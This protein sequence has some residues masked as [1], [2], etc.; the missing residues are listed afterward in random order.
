E[1]YDLAADPNQRNN[2]ADRHPALVEALRT[3]YEA[4][5]ELCSR[6]MGAEIPISIGAEVQATAELRTHDLRN[7]DSDVVWN[8]G[9]IRQGQACLGYWEVL[10]ERA[11][12]Y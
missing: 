5:W 9:Q 8:Q 2:I 3:A 10:V 1:L 6:Q 11:G 12:T 7:A 4:W